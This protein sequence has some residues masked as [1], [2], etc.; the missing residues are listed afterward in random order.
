MNSYIF[1]IDKTKVFHFAKIIEGTNPRKFSLLFVGDE[2]HPLFKEI[3]SQKKNILI[4]T[5]PMKNTDLVS[6]ALLA[7]YMV[8]ELLEF[9]SVIPIIRALEEKYPNALFLYAFQSPSEKR[10]I[11]HHIKK[12]PMVKLID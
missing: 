10:L 12:H 11:E 8:V 9:D 4:F 2:K 7:G 1:P 3:D 6:N 5:L